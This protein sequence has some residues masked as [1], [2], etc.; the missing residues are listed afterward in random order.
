M[1]QAV[2]CPADG[3]EYSGAKSSV[4][5]HYSGMQDANH[6]G[7]Y[8][9]AKEIVEKNS[10][11]GEFIEDD[12]PDGSNDKDELPTGGPST[13][14]A[15]DPDNSGG[16]DPVMG[17]GETGN[18]ESSDDVELPCGHESFNE[19]EAPDPPFGIECSTCGESWTVRE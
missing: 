9:K 10:G 16:K 8:R 2:T 19:D 11:D 1:T 18:V 4:L 14:H 3:C 7:G 5:G 12:E 6:Q 17:S 13:K 15:P